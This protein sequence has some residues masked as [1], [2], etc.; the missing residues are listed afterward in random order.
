MRRTRQRGVRAIVH[1]QGRV[2]APPSEERA[3]PERSF[4]FGVSIYA[5]TKSA[6]GRRSVASGGTRGGGFLCRKNT[7][8]ILSL[9]FFTTVVSSGVVDGAE[10]A[11][12]SP[13]TARG[14]LASAGG[15]EMQCAR[16]FIL[17]V[18]SHTEPSPAPSRHVT[19]HPMLLFLLPLSFVL[20]F[21]LF[22]VV[23]SSVYFRK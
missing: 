17:G 12:A 4:C 11:A 16:A 19:S 6:M 10:E 3:Y 13:S 7:F 1:E 22:H 2:R 20:S 5:C 18:R 15:R 9:I 23:P 21:V 8:M 14:A